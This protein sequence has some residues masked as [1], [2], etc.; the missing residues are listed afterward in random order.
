MFNTIVTHVV[1]LTC[2]TGFGYFTYYSCLGCVFKILASICCFVYISYLLASI[3][4]NAL[5]RFRVKSKN[6]AVFITGCDTGFGQMLARRLDSIGFKVFAGCLDPDGAGA[7]AL[8]DTTTHHLRIVRLN[9]TQD[10]SVRE[11]LETVKKEMGD[12]SL[13][14]LVNNAG[15]IERGELEWTP[16]EVYKK[17]FEVNT[18]GVV[19][20]TQAFLPLL[21][22][23]K[24]RVVTTTSVGGIYN[25]SG[26]GAYCMS[27]HATAS[28]CDVLRLEMAKFGIKVVTIEPFSYQTSMTEMSTVLQSVRNTWSSSLAVRNDPEVYDSEYLRA[29][30]DSVRKFNEKTALPN[31]SEVVDRLVEGVCAI[32]P[33]YSYVVGD[34]MSLLNLWLSRRVPKTVADFFVR[35]NVTFDCDIQLHLQQKELQKKRA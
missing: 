14:A 34:L 3:T 13:W 15:I 1:S 5:P 35:K 27:K 30:S 22:R 26:F 7:R 24:G 29:F 11:A 23:S 33:H 32:S 31:T 21:R 17:Q 25:F 20:V 28:F 10:D 18:F 8:K 9:V 12:C 6:K 2:L 19:R 4:D 16:L